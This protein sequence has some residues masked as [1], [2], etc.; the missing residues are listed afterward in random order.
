MTSV[1]EPQLLTIKPM[2]QRRGDERYCEAKVPGSRVGMDLFVAISHALADWFEKPSETATIYRNTRLA[3][4]LDMGMVMPVDTAR[5]VQAFNDH[6][7]GKHPCSACGFEDRLV[8]W[9][10]ITWNDMPFFGRLCSGCAKEVGL[11]DD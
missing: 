3:M 5:D 10:E 2:R 7:S 11:D 9:V 8:E 4:V 1:P 6:W